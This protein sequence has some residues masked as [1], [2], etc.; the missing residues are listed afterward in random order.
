MAEPLRV[1]DGTLVSAFLN[2]RDT[3]SGLPPDLLGDP[4]GFSIAAGFI[5]AASRSKIHRMP[6][7]AQVTFVLQGSLEVRMKDNDDDA[8]YSLYPVPQQAVLTRAGTFV[9]FINHSALPCQVLY[10]VS[11]AY[12]YELTAEGVLRYDDAVVFEQDWDALPRMNP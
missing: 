7:V 1:A 8:P 10:I 12:V 4:A 3:S 9:Q 5:E 2:P 6:R 11:P